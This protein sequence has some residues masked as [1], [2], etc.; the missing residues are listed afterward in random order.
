MNGKKTSIRSSRN[1]L[2]EFDIIESQG[3][4]S[5]QYSGKNLY[6]V[7]TLVSVISLLLLI[8][9]MIKEKQY[10]MVKID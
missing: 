7:S 8:Y 5:V 2:I 4:V 9:C 10:E 1:K 6:N 3:S